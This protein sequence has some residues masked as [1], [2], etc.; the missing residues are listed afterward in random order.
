M[1]ARR[2]LGRRAR[3][4][5]LYAAALGLAA[6]ATLP[7][8]WMFSTSLKPPRE[9]L[10]TPPTLVPARP[11]LENFARLL[12]ETAFLTY[13]GNSVLVAGLTVL[14]T[15]VVAAAGHITPTVGALLQEG[16]DV[17]VIVNA[18]RTSR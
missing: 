4:G 6:Q 13:L 8:L 16:I 18:L 14:L 1:S 15:M 10:A 11:T 5:L 7:L 3:R 17:A 12:G 2:W 9:V